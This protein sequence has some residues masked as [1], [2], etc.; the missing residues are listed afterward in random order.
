MT[1]LLTKIAAV[2]RKASIGNKARSL[3]FLQKK[4]IKVPETY[5][6]LPDAFK[7]FKTLPEKTLEKLRFEIESSVDLFREYAVRSSANLED[8]TDYSFAGQFK[9]LLNVK[10]SAKIID[11]IQEVWESANISDKSDYSGLINKQSQTINMSVIL[12][13]MIQ[14]LWSGVA[15]SINP[16]NGRSEIV[17]EAVRGLGDKLVQDGQ[18]PCRWVYSQGN[19]ENVEDEFPG[20]DI[21]N[22]LVSD[23]AVLK[24]I[25][26][27]EIDLE[28]AYDGNELQYL[29]LRGL[30]VSRFPTV[31]S[32]HLSREY[33]PGLI[34]PLVWS[35][36]TPLVNSAWLRL[37]EKIVGPTQ[38]KPEQLSHAFY[39][40]AYF[41]MGTMGAL[42]KLMGLPANSL[43]SLM[44]RKDPSGKSA[45]KPSVKTF[46]LI[47]R[48]IGFILSNLNIAGKFERNFKKLRSE[49]NQLEDRLDAEFDVGRFE[50]DYQELL[51]LGSALAYFNIVIPLMMQITNAILRKKLKKMGIE[52]SDVVLYEM[53]PQIREYNPHDH[54]EELQR[55]WNLLDEAQK[56]EISESILNGKAGKDAGEFEIAF[57]RF[58]NTY[59]HF[60]ESGNDF[61][62]P[63]WEEDRDFVL[64]VLIKSGTREDDQSSVNE[65]H[66]NKLERIRK[67]KSTFRK[68][69]RAGRYRLYREMIS[70][71]Y[72]RGYGL[73]RKLF[74]HVG[75]HLK[76]KDLLENIE[77]V[78]YLDIHELEM[79]LNQDAKWDEH[80]TKKHISAIKKDME[81]AENISLPSVIYGEDPP[82]IPK[83][84]ETM[85]TGIP[86]SPGHFEG[87]VVVVKGYKDFHKVKEGC[88]LIIP[89][90]DVGWMP[91]LTKAGAIVSE[92][93][94]MLSHASIIARELGIPAIASVDYACNVKDGTHVKLDCNNGS[95]L[96]QKSP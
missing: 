82:L 30:T 5:V 87:E 21:L 62:V 28:W 57:N 81:E 12:Q 93:G 38:I 90:S 86:I 27:H 4:K 53:Y 32:N 67:S 78:F 94:G 3:Q 35:V 50:S 69:R 46:L 56:Q 68:Y 49:A 17:V 79:L 29:Q 66:K 11:A 91:I 22:K 19:W 84:D 43:E 92:S 9:T 72:T 96:I 1:Q 40:R 10:G 63:S 51:K 61:S 85:L 14:P 44:G 95:I 13:E 71:E 75:R 8:Q 25:K 7:E 45:F 41:N 48:M 80:S 23:V 2:P 74:L 42:F 58:I 26:K 16:V 24:R 83:Q 64:N 76:A 36:N 54:L 60:S 39:Y 77:D 89:F 65:G 70:S 31:Y 73:F 37:L 88:V 15:F 55:R 6:V 52:Y 18:T 34:K 47:P 20:Y 59:G 33:L